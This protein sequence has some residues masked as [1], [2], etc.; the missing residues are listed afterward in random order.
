MEANAPLFATKS[1]AG[2]INRSF[3]LARSR[4]RTRHRSC[5]SSL[6]V[7][8]NWKE[9]REEVRST[10]CMVQTLD[11]T[12]FSS[13]IFHPS[14]L[15]DILNR[16]TFHRWRLLSVPLCLTSQPPAGPDLPP[17][18]IINSLAKRESYTRVRSRTHKRTGAQRKGK[19]AKAYYYYYHYDA[20]S[21]GSF[22]ETRDGPVRMRS[23]ICK[24]ALPWAVK[25]RARAHQRR[26]SDHLPLTGNESMTAN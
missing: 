21:S 20:S 16:V 3:A 17:R 7:R 4:M 6:A 18:W 26:V 23:A 14:L 25:E 19:E 5:E 22:P 12:Q 9:K 11:G 24:A 1:S 2:M 8:V 15:I 10:S 13:L